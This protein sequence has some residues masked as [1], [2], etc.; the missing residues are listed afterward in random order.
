MPSSF[1]V[2]ST[3]PEDAL[4]RRHGWM[5]WQGRGWRLAPRDRPREADMHCVIAHYT[6]SFAAKLRGVP[7]QR[8]GVV[9]G[10]SAAGLPLDELRNAWTTA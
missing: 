1:W 5:P 4:V 10:D 7:I 8:L 6:E 9:R 3:K 2:A